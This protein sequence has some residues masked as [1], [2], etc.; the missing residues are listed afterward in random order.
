VEPLV[1]DVWLPDLQVMAARSVS[2]RRDGFYLAAKGGHNDESHN[3]NDV[4]NFIAY[5]DGDPVLIDAGAQTYTAATF[6]SRRY[7]L[8]NNQSG[9]HNLPTINGVMQREGRAFAARNLRYEAGADFAR[10]SLD[11]AGAYPESARVESWHRMMTLNRRRNVEVDESYR[12]SASTSPFTLNFLTPLQADAAGAG[13]VRLFGPDNTNPRAFVLVYDADR[14]D[15]TVETIPVTDTRMRASWGEKLQRVVLK[16]K[17]AVLA[18][19]FV[20]RLEAQ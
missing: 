9:F 10:L 11:L 7:E 2:G 13:R 8:W 18:D 17:K 14:F 3:H 20:V 15:P 4:G 5:Y 12:L 1:G 6:S 16:S 19:R